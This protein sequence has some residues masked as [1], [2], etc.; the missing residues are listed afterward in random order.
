MKQNP[1]ALAEQELVRRKIA[2]AADLRRVAASSKRILSSPSVIAGACVGGVVLGYL[3]TG[4]SGNQDHRR[5]NA[6]GWSPVLATAQL[7]VPLIRIVSTAR[8][9]KTVPRRSSIAACNVESR[10]VRARDR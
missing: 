9:F 5:H 1:V 10:P 2:A 7:L 3:A 4:R 8:R 6:A